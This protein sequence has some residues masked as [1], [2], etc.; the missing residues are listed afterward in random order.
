VG[1]RH[2]LASGVR[3]TFV[4]DDDAPPVF[5][6][7]FALLTVDAER[8]LRHLD[9]PHIKLRQ[10]GSNPARGQAARAIGRTKGGLNTKLSAV[11]DA[12]GRSVEVS[13]APNQQHDQHAVL[14]LLAGVRQRRI[15]FDKGFVRK[16]SD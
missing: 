6:Q 12:R 13:L 3:F 8:E 4:I 9:C 14:P 2:V 5:F 7:I 15:V 1:C 10:H 11:V 16:S